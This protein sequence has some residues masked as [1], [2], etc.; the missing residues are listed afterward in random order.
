MN[1]IKLE[2]VEYALRCDINV[3]EK[4]EGKYGSPEKLFESGIAGVKDVAAWMINEHRYYVGERDTITP[5]YIG[6][7]LTYP[8]YTAMCDT[9]VA[10]LADCM[11]AKN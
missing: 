10:E 11:K 4:I 6:A 9:I 2:G 8:E 1:V 5:D 7:R 3:I